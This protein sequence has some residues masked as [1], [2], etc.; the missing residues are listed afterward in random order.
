MWVHLNTRVLLRAICVLVQFV[1]YILAVPEWSV[2]SFKEEAQT[3][4]ID[5]G[6]Q[7]C[8]GRR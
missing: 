6:L 8:V 1:P 3:V 4:A 7:Q 5:K 2:R